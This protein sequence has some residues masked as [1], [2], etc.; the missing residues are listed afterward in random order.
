M[1]LARK[2]YAWAESKALSPLAPLWLGLIFLGELVLFIPFDA[3]LMLFCLRNP[4]RKGLYAAVATC[5]SIL[6]AIIGYGMGLLLWDTIGPFVIKYL[7]SAEF[8]NRFVEHY[9]RHASAAVLIGSLLPIPFKAV[10]L[11]AGFCQISFGTYILSVAIARGVRFCLL[12]E[13]MCR[14]SSPIKRFID[15]NFNYLIWGLGAK[16]ALSLTFFWPW[17]N[18]SNRKTLFF[19]SGACSSV[20]KAGICH[21]FSYRNGLRFGRS[22][23]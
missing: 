23:F 22:Y 20:A 21:C 13:I 10:T 18:G 17:D 15:R 11:S 7:V 6:T 2:A 5:S 12:A 3:L 16:I 4:E 1:H 9:N 8:F 14:W 19:S